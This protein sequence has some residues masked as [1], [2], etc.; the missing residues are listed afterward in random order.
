TFDGKPTSVYAIKQFTQLF[1]QLAS[2]S[3]VTLLHISKSKEDS[4]S[5]VDLMKE[6]LTVHYPSLNY[7]T[8]SGQ[9]DDAILNFAEMQ[10]NPLIVLGAYGRS[11]VSRFFSKSTAGKLLKGRSLPVFV[12]HK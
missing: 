11:G 12:A 3:A 10:T 5:N 2:R 6:Y 9:A 7:E 4:T 1:H 8:I